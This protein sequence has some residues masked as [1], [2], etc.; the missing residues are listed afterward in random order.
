M[1]DVMLKVKSPFFT[2]VKVCCALHL[3]EELILSTERGQMVCT[4]EVCHTSRQD[5]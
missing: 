4:Q 2:L 3:P 5:I 1:N